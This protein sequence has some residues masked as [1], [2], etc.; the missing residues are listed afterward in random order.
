[1]PYV[2][3]RSLDEAVALLTKN[4][5]A[6]VLAGGHTLLL[7]PHRSTLADKLLVDLRYVPNLSGVQPAAVRAP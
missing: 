1:M 7:E 6:L 5:G 2:A 4:Q 3:P